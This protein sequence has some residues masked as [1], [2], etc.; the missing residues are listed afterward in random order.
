MD[1]GSQ[2]PA[3]APLE[4]IAGVWAAWGRLPDGFRFCARTVAR[5]AERAGDYPAACWI[6]CHPGEYARGVLFG[7]LDGPTPDEESHRL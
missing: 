6:K 1:G 4:V 5:E 3:R 7:F 2:R